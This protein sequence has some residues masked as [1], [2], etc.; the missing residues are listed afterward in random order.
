MNSYKQGNHGRKTFKIHLQESI[1]QMDNKTNG[2]NFDQHDSTP[3]NVR[4]SVGDIQRDRNDKVLQ[5]F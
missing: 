5:C 4:F 1:H 3:T 2:S